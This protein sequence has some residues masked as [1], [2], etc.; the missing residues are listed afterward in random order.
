MKMIRYEPTRLRYR[1]FHSGPLESLG[2]A[3]E[4]IV[5]LFHLID[6]ALDPSDHTLR[7]ASKLLLGFGRK[8]NA[9]A[10]AS[11]RATVWTRPA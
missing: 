5:A 3:P 6:L 1:P 4:R 8:F 2:V 10:N 11:R 9:V 7:E